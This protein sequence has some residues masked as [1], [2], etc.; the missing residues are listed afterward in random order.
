LHPLPPDPL[1]FPRSWDSR[2]RTQPPIHIRGTRTALVVAV[3]VALA[4]VVGVIVLAMLAWPVH[5]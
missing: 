3:Q 1:L 2:N 5:A 4:F